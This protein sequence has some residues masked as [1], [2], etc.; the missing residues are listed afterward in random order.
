[1]HKHTGMDRGS[2]LLAVLNVLTSERDRTHLS[3][4][5][6]P[7]LLRQLLADSYSS[8]LEVPDGSHVSQ[9]EFEQLRA[10]HSFIQS[11]YLKVRQHNFL[12]SLMV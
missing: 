2:Q 10:M 5:L 1:M 3:P 6:Y 4:L 12:P 11:S 9:K 7:G 8:P